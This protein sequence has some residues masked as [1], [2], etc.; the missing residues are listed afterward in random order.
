M[1]WITVTLGGEFWMELPTTT[2]GEE[3]HDRFQKHWPRLWC[4]WTLTPQI[5]E[6]WHSRPTRNVKSLDSR[7]ELS[8]FSETCTCMHLSWGTLLKFQD[9]NILGVISWESKGPPPPMP[10]YFE[11]IA[12]LMRR[13][14]RDN[15]GFHNPLIRRCISWGR[16][17]GGWNW[18]G[19]DP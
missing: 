1:I 18:R 11:E 3:G 5:N 9:W 12:S 6:Y 16:G 13:F 17:V 2:W 7:N 14:L 10:S 4:Y 15:D 8:E 19:W